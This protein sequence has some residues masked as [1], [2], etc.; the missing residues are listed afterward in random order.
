MSP[1]P[2][3]QKADII[4]SNGVVDIIDH[5][6]LLPPPVPAPSPAPP[7]PGPSPPTPRAP[8]PAPPGPG[9]S[10][11]TPQAP[12]PAAAG[13]CSQLPKFK[14]SKPDTFFYKD[15]LDLGTCCMLC[16]DFSGPGV[17]GAYTVNSTGC[18]LKE[19]SGGLTP[20]SG[21]N[22]G[23]SPPTPQVPTPPPVKPTPPPTPP[24]V[25]TPAI[26]QRGA[27]QTKPRSLA[28]K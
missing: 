18:A 3:S 21:S 4:A 15:I 9:P 25:R 5:V 16:I 19:D 20:D 13:K 28:G 24:P 6:L 14:I 11:P 1:P 8:T 22:S 10:P 7:G 27:S 2:S 26:P 17:C 23:V 12:T